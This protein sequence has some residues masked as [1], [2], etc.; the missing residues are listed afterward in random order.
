MG[1]FWQVDFLNSVEAKA[2]IFTWYV[3]PNETM[4]IYKFK[5]QGLRTHVW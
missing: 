4:A 1:F 3:K 2:I 5:G